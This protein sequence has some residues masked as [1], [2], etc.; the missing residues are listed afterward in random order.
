MSNSWLSAAALLLSALSTTALAES[1]F[2]FDT[3]PGKL[4]KTVVPEHYSLRVT[5][6]LEKNTFQGEVSIRIR[7]REEVREIVLNAANL[8]IRTARLSGAG[9]APVDLKPMLD[10]KSELLRFKLRK[11]LKPETYALNITYSGQL[12]GQTSGFYYGHYVNESGE[13]QKMLSSQLEPADARRL[14]PCWDEPVFRAS[15]QAAIDLPPSM[16]AVSNTPVEGVEKLPNGLHRTRFQPTPKMSSYLLVLVAGPLERLSDQQDGVDIGIVTAAGKRDTGKYALN[17]SKEL[18]RYFNEYFGIAYPLPK[19]DQ[20]AVPS[21]AG[22]GAME[23]WGGIT[24]D[25]AVLLYDPRTSSDSTRRGIYSV[26][27]HEMAHQWFGDLV[28]MAWW[29]NLWLNEG[30]ASWMGT[31]ATDHANREWGVWRE[32]QFEREAAMSLDARESTHP[33]QQAVTDESQA[34]DAF[35]SITYL[36]GQSFLRMLETWLGADTFRDGIRAYVAKHKYSNTTTAD[37]WAALEKASGK[38]VTR[39]AQ[40]WTEQSGFPVVQVRAR[41][42][43]GKRLISLRQE[44]FRSDAEPGERLWVIPVALSSGGTL[45]YELLDQRA[46]EF[47]RPGCAGALVLDPEAVG[48]YRVEY[49]PELLAELTKNWRRLSVD[50]RLKLLSDAW[51]L[52]ETGRSPLAGYLSM[53]EQARRDPEPAITAQILGRLNHLDGLARD[54]AARPALRAF[55]IKVLR[56]RLDKLGWDAGRGDSQESLELRARLIAVLGEFGDAGVRAE[57]GKRFAKFLKDPASLAAGLADPVIET[58]GRSASAATWE[59]LYQRAR[60]AS[61]S[62]EQR[63]YIYAMCV[64]EDPVLARRTLE[65]SLG[66]TLPISLATG[67]PRLVAL[68][69]QAQAW[70]FAKVNHLALIKRLPTYQLNSYFGEVVADS[71]DAAMADELEK[72]AS[73]NLPATAMQRTRRAAVGIRINAVQKQRL[74]PQLSSMGTLPFELSI[75][76]NGANGDAPL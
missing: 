23:N 28:T 13:K 2:S 30:F 33:I 59:L 64:N 5:P 10:P 58:V 9:L 20:I 26:I 70:E 38:P 54:D 12:N 72:W 42:E 16:M 19:L 1:P 15:F 6:D 51:A 69:H 73:Q 25:E 48:F 76:A 56:P 53:V 40:G 31:K 49:A 7:V 60:T 66:E 67:I 27:A 65:L 41:C 14:L 74:L 47:S 62:E 24:Y 18:L 57:A 22:F 34:T 17:A 63:R 50:T 55:A 4:P 75:V 37:L 39:M 45:A 71:A 8:D 43:A 3:T 11:P 21:T 46:R 61:G 35:D 36:K 68:Q 44:Q 29:D 52:A 32:A